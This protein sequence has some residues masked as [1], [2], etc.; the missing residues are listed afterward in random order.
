MIV[1]KIGFQI[2]ALVLAF[3]SGSVSGAPRYMR[4]HVFMRLLALFAVGFAVLSMVTK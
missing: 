4:D 2:M 3:G 1:V